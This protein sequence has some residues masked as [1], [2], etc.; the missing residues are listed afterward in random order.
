MS[1]YDVVLNADGTLKSAVQIAN[2]DTANG[3]KWYAYVRTPNTHG[4]YN[5]QTYVDTMSK[6]AMDEFIR[7]TYE[8]YKDHV[9]EGF[10]ETIPAIFTD[11]PQ[12]TSKTPLAFAHEK[13]EVCLPWTTDLEAVFREQYG[14]DLLEHLPELVWDLPEGQPSQTRYYYHDLVCELFTSAFADNCGAWC[15]EHNI[16]LTGHMMQENSLNL[17]TRFNGEAMRFYRS[18]ALPGIDVLCDI[19]ELSAAKQAQSACHQY[20]REGMMSELYGVTNWTFDFRGHKFQGDWQAALGVTVRVPHLSWVSMKGSAKR[21]F[22]ASIS[23]Q[24]PWYKEYSYIEDHFARLNT[25]LTRGKPVVKVGVIHPVE[26][27]WL[28]FGPLETTAVIRRQLEESFKTMI[29][30]LLFGSIDY[31]YISEA[32]LPSQYGGCAGEALAVGEMK[33]ETILVSGCE[34][35]RSSTVKILKEFVKNGGKVVFV[36]D[37]PKYVDA[38]PSEEIQELFDAA[39]HADKSRVSV[40]EQLADVRTVSIKGADASPT[41]DLIYQLRE[42]G[43]VSWLFIAH[44]KKPRFSD[45]MNPRQITIQLPGEYEPVIYDTM[46][47]GVKPI[48]FAIENGVTTMKHTLHTHDSLLVQLKRPNARCC[49][50]AGRAEA[51][52]K[53]IYIKN[54]VEY[55][56]EEPNVYLLDMAQYSLDDGK[57]YYETEEVLRLDEQIRKELN[58]PLADGGDTQPWTIPPEKIA[59]FPW[60]K[61]EIESDIAVRCNLAYEEAE[62][63]ILNGESV[64]IAENGFFVDHSIKTMELPMLKAGKNELLIRVPIG[65]RTSI[66][67]FFLTGEFDVEVRG[68]EKKIIA[69]NKT[70]GFGSITHQGLPFYGG[71]VIYKAKVNLP[72]GNLTIRTN[73]YRGALVRVRFD[74]EDRGVIAFDPYALDIGK[75]SEG[76]HTVERTLFGNRAKP[77]RALHIRGDKLPTWGWY[78][79]NSWYLRGD[80]WS[81][82]YHLYD[83]GIMASPIFEIR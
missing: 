74:G 69:P 60:L 3:C 18:F 20:G 81:Y 64:A 47:G 54:A 37:M 77:F 79:P 46:D 27:Y 61:F 5:N 21:D 62:E 11:E 30:W 72:E 82:D 80:E 53:E 31:D 34:T 38:Q 51:E 25:A 44:A 66:E 75:I 73:E 4:W 28:H 76:E 33:Y 35:L 48:A 16:A 29:D 9:G 32:L 26:S 49:E 83:T 70:I 43:N 1:C 7:V 19:I 52:T 57:T 71:N 2:D 67:N 13:G 78:G 58:Y 23:Y 24:S 50:P 8:A 40:L 63:V 42:D 68:C 56:R 15:K 17:Q 6:P 14:I 55:C 41:E 22:P 65:K 39:E 45:N 59:H 10:G 36:G 12:V